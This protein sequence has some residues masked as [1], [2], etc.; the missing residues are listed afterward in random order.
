MC[1]NF[2]TLLN[3]Y[4]S[5]WLC[6][7]QQLSFITDLPSRVRDDSPNLS[8]TEN[9]DDEQEKCMSLEFTIIHLKNM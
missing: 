7:E 6:A 4:C 5:V 2:S 1:E 3:S 9:N 8:K